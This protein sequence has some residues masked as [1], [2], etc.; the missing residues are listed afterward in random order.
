MKKIFYLLLIALMIT[1]LCSCFDNKNENDIRGE[2]IS[3]DTLKNETE[4]ITENE[5]EF[6]IGEVTSNTY[7]NKFLGL[8][9]TL[10][11]E[12]VFYTD[13]QM[14]QLNNIAKDFLDD[15]AKKQLESATLIYDMYATVEA[16]GS[17]INVNLEKL[18]PVQALSLNI[19]AS[20]EAQIDTI[21]T[22]YENM[23]YTD[24]DIFYERVTVD[25]KELDG[26]KINAKIQG[27]DFYGVCF[28]FEKSNYL[29]NTMICTLLTDETE[30]I[31]N[32]FK[33]K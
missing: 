8:S 23:G 28:A 24:I 30:S 12:W 20:L 31:L 6:S 25:G 15:E 5:P 13:E 1:S 32:C 9:C 11:S 17:T 16:D 33:L 19:K 3:G 18:N 10:P 14:L 26:L 2:I 27:I 21:K 29:A 4:N 7:S 22:A